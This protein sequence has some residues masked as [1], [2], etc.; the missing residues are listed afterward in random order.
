M[1]VHVHFMIAANGVR[2]HWDEV[3]YVT[4]KYIFAIVKI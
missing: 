4:M 2:P 3:E 1:K